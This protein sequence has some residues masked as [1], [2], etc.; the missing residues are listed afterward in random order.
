M[1]WDH[2]TDFLV[3][4][5]GAGG[6]TAALTAKLHGAESLVLEKSEMYGGTS[7]MSGGALWVPCNHLMEAAG[8]AD[9]AEDAWTYLQ[10][11]TKGRTP[12]R[13]L[14][15]YLEHAARMVRFLA[16]RTHA[17]FTSLTKYPDYYPETPGGRPGGRSIEA[18]QFD[19]KKLGRELARLRPPH[20]QE[21]I[22][23]RVMMGAAEAHDALFG[24]REA[25]LTVV[26][27]LLGYFFNVWERL[28]WRRDTRLTIGN[29]LCARLRLSMLEEGVPLWLKTRVTELVV[30]GGAVRGVVAERDGKRVRIGARKGVLLAAGG[31]ARSQRF[32][33]RF[34]KPGIGVDWTAASREDTGDA[35]ALTE[36]L[37][38]ALDLMD[39]AWWTPT[40][41]PPGESQ[42]WILVVE[43][44][45]PGSILVNQDGER[46]TNEAAPYLE[47]VDGILADQAKTGGRT[48]PC[49]LVVDA[50][51]R[52][53]Y[54]LGPILPGGFLPE[55]FWKK[56]WRAWAVK[57]P[58]IG[59]L[60]GK[61]GIDPARLESTIERFNGFCREGKDRDFGRGDSLYDR[62]Y[63]SPKVKPNPALGRLERGP[64]YAIPVWP[65]DL[66]T[67]GGIVT[68]EHARALREDGSVVRG[69][70]ATGN[71][72]ASVMAKTYPGAGG[73]IG[74]AMTFGYVAALH[75]L[76]ATGALS[77]DSPRVAEAATS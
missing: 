54:P 30:D 73:T 71:S 20:P 14:R 58:T 77:E 25:Q 64:F 13:R 18:E 56:A 10:A 72:S 52:Q 66:G 74:P 23:G 8:I 50:R 19:G 53:K 26:K 61:L 70:Y 46:F 57:A 1:S 34:A 39:E 11:V 65:G 68:D 47:V 49:Y 15:A 51:C 75:A 48:V 6:M 28:V 27:K 4:G 41:L 12:E 3:V 55:A 35:L 2:E 63:A 31:F 38:V 7:A 62:Y 69:L 60:A 45:L 24:G 32:R 17:R 43:K 67:K 33:E 42:P 21:C 76:G 40:M 44:A 36:T 9:S 59:A 29:A 5:S 16:D 22:A 37:G